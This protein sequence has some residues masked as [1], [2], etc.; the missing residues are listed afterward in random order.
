MD[1]GVYTP[2][3]ALELEQLIDSPS[4][5]SAIHSGLVDEVKANRIEPNSVRNFIQTVLNQLLEFNE[6]R[7]KTDDRTREVVRDT[8]PPLSPRG[9]RRADGRGTGGGSDDRAVDRAVAA[10]CGP[11]QGGLCQRHRAGKGARTEPRG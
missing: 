9:N 6:E 8:S 5:Q 10:T 2:E 11:G 1:L 7:V 3:H 4:W